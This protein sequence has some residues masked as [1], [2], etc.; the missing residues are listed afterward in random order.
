MWKA[1]GR[2]SS[3]PSRC[4]EGRR[5]ANWTVPNRRSIAYAAVTR[6]PALIS[7]ACPFCSTRLEL[8]AVVGDQQRG[9]TSCGRAFWV[10]IA[11]PSVST[12]PPK[13]VGSTS[14]TVTDLGPVPLESRETVLGLKPVGAMLREGERVTRGPVPAA[15][16]RPLPA[17]DVSDE[18]TDKGRRARGR[19]IDDDL[20]APL[21][22]TIPPKRPTSSR[23]LDPKRRSERRLALPD[24]PPLQA[25][26]G[27]DLGGLQLLACI[28][29]G[30]M[31]TV[32]L[33]RQLS[34]DRNVAVKI[35][36]PNLGDDPAF[37]IQFTREALAAAQLVHH[38]IVQI[39]DIGLEQHL[40]Y[41]SMEYVEG[42]SLAALLKREGRLDPEVATG[43]VLQAARGLQ[44]AHARGMIHRDIK[45][46]NLLLNRDG[47]VKVADLGL[48]KRLDE[49][50]PARAVPSSTVA[51]LGFGAG[52]VVMGTPAYMA[53]EQVLDSTSVDARADVYSLG[54]TLYDLLIGH[55]PFEGESSVQV[56]SLHLTHVAVAPSERNKRVPA[57]LSDLV[58][59]M[60]AKKPGDRPQGMEA[61][62]AALEHFLGIDSAALFSPKEE[63]AA[64]LERSVEA[65]NGALQARRRRVARLG[66]LALS[67]TVVLSALFLGFPAFAAWSFLFIGTATATSFFIN[68]FT[69]RATLLLKLRH[70]LLGAPLWNWT[71]VFGG[72]GVCI[73]VLAWNRLLWG[74]AE[75]LGLAAA[76]G[77][78]SFLTVD[79]KVA[80]E[81]RPF[82]QA[83]EEML[84]AM[85]LKGLEEL[86][87]RQFVCRYSGPRW[88]E[89]YEAL[90]GY[91]AKLDARGR[92][93][94]DEKGL[95]RKRH[96]AWRD[97]LL[98][99]I[100]RRLELR[101]ARRAA[102]QLDRVERQ[103]GAPP[104]L[105]MRR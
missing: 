21:G 8:D 9:C 87:L 29:G 91:D 64:L 51:D 54:C 96:A 10:S 1:P 62:V 77:L 100:E 3:I 43:Y 50:E 82:V 46:E 76:V 66:F 53:P 58:L 15:A 61:V 4:G 75:N 24:A 68:A 94:R 19:A 102:A 65:F 104:P 16:P 25:V 47:I 95:P 99:F 55:P 59:E 90:F 72:L 93:G 89:F 44:F 13:A 84:K 70:L 57:E 105:P 42:E 67:A 56:L 7:L 71:A 33:A 79:R 23:K 22:V 41:F 88:E 37:V 80:R 81:R 28:G 52:D 2:G 86:K 63:H 30:G 60:M 12:A 49:R 97:P 27:L 35:L 103:A 45:P 73:G 101:H 18:E 38:N 85:R 26:P 14:A 5:D 83:I 17:F 74:V 11:A 92:W 78:A 98:R 40:H 20:G 32:W 31:G 34:L 48:V 36:R 39:Y 6:W 69:E